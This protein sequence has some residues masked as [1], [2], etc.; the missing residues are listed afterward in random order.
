MKFALFAPRTAGVDVAALVARMTS[1]LLRRPSQRTVFVSIGRAQIGLVVGE[2]DAD[3]IFH[4]SNGNRLLVAG[5]PILLDGDLRQAL[6]RAVAVGGAVAR[7]V[8]QSL[9][10]AF[11]AVL[12]E[13]QACRLTLVGDRLGEEPLYAAQTQ[14]GIA[15]ASGMFA[16]AAAFTR[17][18]AIDAIGC[19]AFLRFGNL[20]GGRSWVEGVR[21]LPPAV[22]G[23]IDDEGRFAESIHWRTPNAIEDR[24]GTFDVQG[25]AE[26]VEREVSA[27]QR[28]YGEATLLLSGGF[29]SRFIAAA[30]NRKALPF[31][32]LIVAHPDLGNADGR[33]ATALARRLK[34]P[35]RVVDA[36]P[37]SDEAAAERYLDDTEISNPSLGL[38]IARVADWVARNRPRAV[39]DGLNLGFTMAGL[40]T[41]M[42][43]PRELT[44]RIDELPTARLWRAAQRLFTPRFM[45]ELRTAWAALE[46][47]VAENYE[48]SGDGL[49]HFLIESR[50]RRRTAAHSLKAL[51]NDT[52]PFTPGL[53]R[54]FLDRVFR[55]PLEIR[56]SVEPYL[57]LFR[58]RYTEAGGVPIVSGAHFYNVS[59]RFNPRFAFEQTRAQMFGHWRIE[60]LRRH[61]GN[62]NGDA[63]SSK[64][65]L[66]RA[67]DDAPE[68]SSLDPAAIARLRRIDIIT[69]DERDA[70]ELLGYWGAVSRA[71]S[72]P[73][74]F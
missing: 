57:A 66:R 29:D 9:D 3:L 54:D 37:E 39:W 51:A 67:L 45:D 40:Y 20:I 38:F 64:S 33:L 68:D 30:L 49:Q 62:A 12:F 26:A 24:A 35:S 56:Q 19:A 36:L 18:P 31:E 7:T 27:Y 16:A 46:R 48:S 15:V 25:L 21:R 28:T 71:L 69:D 6:D 65:F 17:R 14:A 47:S 63:V 8:L 70:V 11:A 44:M 23:Q 55:I 5:Q 22:I 42:A 61:L 41:P 13:A 43:N 60:A 50:V 52:I 32:A 34:A 58:R 2:N 74:A 59:S 10:G 73:A 4:A 53:G 1:N 72:R